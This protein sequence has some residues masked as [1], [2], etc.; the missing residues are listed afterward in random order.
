M[1]SRNGISKKCE[2][3]SSWSYKTTLTE[4]C[5]IYH[6]HNGYFDPNGYGDVIGTYTHE[7]KKSEELAD[8]Y[9]R[10]VLQLN[11]L[12]NS[13]PKNSIE[14]IKS[15]KVKLYIV[16]ACSKEQMLSIGSFNQRMSKDETK[17][18]TSKIKSLDSVDSFKK[19]Y[20]NLFKE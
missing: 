6:N 18:H 10:P 14:L 16:A 1:V 15:K 13:I 20:N 9:F 11:E 2:V 8:F 4:F 19:I 17:Y 7:A 3:R 5:D 12:Q